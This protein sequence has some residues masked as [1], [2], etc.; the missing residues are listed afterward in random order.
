MK[1]KDTLIR[2][3]MNSVC[4]LLFRVLCL[5]IGWHRPL[6]LTSKPWSQPCV[7]RQEGGLSGKLCFVHDEN[8]DELS[9][10]FYARGWWNAVDY[11]WMDYRVLWKMCFMVV[12][13]SPSVVTCC[14]GN[15]V[16]LCLDSSWNTAVLGW[17][18]W[19]AFC[20]N[21]ISYVH[22]FVC[23]KFSIHLHPPEL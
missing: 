13:F 21:F 11:G 1:P 15:V 22:V 2:F 20:D 9:A 14:M 3:I 6:I 23:L 18:K 4:V 7:D 8:L 12:L 19:V 16:P 5:F 17:C 10:G